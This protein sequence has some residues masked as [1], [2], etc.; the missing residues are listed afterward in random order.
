MIRSANRSGL[1][2]A[3]GSVWLRF[4]PHGPLPAHHPRVPKNYT[5]IITS[6]SG[7]VEEPAG[8]S[9]PR[10]S[11]GRR[12]VFWVLPQVAQL[13]QWGSRIIKTV[14]RRGCDCY[15][16]G[17]LVIKL[18]PAW[19]R[20]RDQPPA[21]GT[22]RGEPLNTLRYGRFDEKKILFVTCNEVGR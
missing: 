21:S 1:A 9:S 11:P 8:W 20:T 17:V 18:S 3:S 14:P 10:F 19:A 7:S 22:L 12:N 4:A 15:T 2:P 6:A 5:R 13:P 16:S